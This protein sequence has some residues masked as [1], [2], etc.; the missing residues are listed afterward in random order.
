MNHGAFPLLLHSNRLKSKLEERLNTDVFIGMCFGRPSMDECLQAVVDRQVSRIMIVPMHPHYASSASGISIEKAIRGLSKFP[1]IPEIVSLN[2]F[3]REKGY[4]RAFAERIKEYD[5]KSF[6]G[7]VFSYHSL[8]LAH[9]KKIDA[10]YPAEC[11][12]TTKL[13][14]AELGIETAAT[15]F[16]S[17][18]GRKWLCPAT[19]SVV[20]EML[21]NGKTR[22]LVVAPSFVSDCLETEIELGVELKEVFL[23]N[24]GKELQVVQSLNEHPV[25]IDFLAQK[26]DDLMNR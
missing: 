20:M 3:F 8:P 26:Y 15:G 12:E 11:V 4:I 10:N 5:C 1:F 22:I 9:V 24:G 18:M 17:Q 21:K 19:Q 16:Q 23:Q 25:W 14:C 13:I 6:D 2:S 7:I